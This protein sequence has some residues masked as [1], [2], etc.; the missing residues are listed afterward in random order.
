[1]ALE[2]LVL[3]KVLKPAQF[4]TVAGALRGALKA[5]RKAPR[6]KF[7]LGHPKDF[8]RLARQKDSN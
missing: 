7:E 8:D 5:I 1:M 6:R 2:D 3:Q 4:N